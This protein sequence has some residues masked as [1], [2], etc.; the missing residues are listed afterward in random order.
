MDNEFI[1][2]NKKK[3]VLSKVSAALEFSGTT[4]MLKNCQ[5]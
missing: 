3:P 4:K 5:T 2:H 1:I